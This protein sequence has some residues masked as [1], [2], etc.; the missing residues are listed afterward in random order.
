I[1]KILKD[2]DSVFLDA[3]DMR[4]VDF[5]DNKIQITA[6][7]Q[8]I[9]LVK[10]FKSGKDYSVRFKYEVTPKQT[11]YFMSDDEM[12]T[13]G[14]GKYTSHWLPSLDDTNDKIEFDLT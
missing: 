6:S 12:W 10:K 1:F 13:Q 7:K 3:K 5:D 9:W 8:K 11:F 4:I 14:Q 2:T